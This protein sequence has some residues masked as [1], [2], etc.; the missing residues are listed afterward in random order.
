MIESSVFRF[1]MFVVEVSFFII[2][3]FFITRYVQQ[4]VTV[5]YVCYVMFFLGGGSAPPHGP[6]WGSAPVPAFLQ[7]HKVSSGFTNHYTK[8]NTN[9]AIP[10]VK[11]TIFVWADIIFLFF[12]SPNTELKSRISE[13]LTILSTN[14]VK[15]LSCEIWAESDNNLAVKM[16]FF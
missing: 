7:W 12:P 13:P 14:K 1:Y 3:F 6:G 16:D 9:Q 2:I 8:L 5:C 11:I 15:K 4:R 10:L